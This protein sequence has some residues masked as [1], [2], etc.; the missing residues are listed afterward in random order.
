[1]AY[2]GEPAGNGKLD[3]YA[4][5]AEG[6]LALAAVADWIQP[7][8]SKVWTDRAEALVDAARNHFRDPNSP[9]FYYISDD[10]EQLVHRKKEWF[11]NAIPSGNS[12]LLQ[13]L[14]SLDLLT[15]N[16][17]YAE[18]IDRMR[19]AY[20]GII[21]SA[22][23]A[24]SHAL[25]A[26]VSQAIG[27]AVIKVRPGADLEALRAALAA[28]PWRPVY[29]QVDDSGTLSADFQLCVGTEC[30][31]PTDSVGEVVEVL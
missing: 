15:G 14:V 29:L 22:P 12:S 18:E 5:A 3:D 8:R 23:S 9:G 13:S 11:D 26:L 31:A 27:I 7:G 24:A 2:E 21:H 28:R 1:M 19:L 30:L 25:S 20:P 4:F 6:F 17:E 10:H 16:P